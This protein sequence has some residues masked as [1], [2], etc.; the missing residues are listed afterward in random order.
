MSED[1]V[2]AKKGPFGV[3]VKKDQTYWWCACG[4]SK[5][6]P[7]C[8]GSHKGTSF[9]PIKYVADDNVMVAFCG[10][11]QSR[12]KPYCDDSHIAIVVE[13][14]EIDESKKPRLF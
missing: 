5:S 1:A 4:L 8:D 2:M 12:I 14:E 9:E 3:V 7:F 6:Q 10:C 13:E 11:K